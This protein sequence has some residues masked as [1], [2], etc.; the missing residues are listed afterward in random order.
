VTSFRKKETR[1]NQI[2]NTNILKLIVTFSFVSTLA[3]IAQSSSFTYQGRLNDGAVPA[4]G[5][6]DIQFALYDASSNGTQQGDL[7]TNSAVT[8]SNGLFTVLLDFGNQFPGAERWLQIGVRSNAVGSFTVVVPRQPLSASPYAI[9]AANL[10]G[11]VAASQ[12]TGT[13]PIGSLAGGYSNALTLANPGNNFSGNGA[14]LVGVNAASLQGLGTASLWQTTGNAGTTP[15]NNFI[16]TTDNQAFELRVNGFRGF[17]LQPN[18]GGSPNV[19]GGS[20]L[21]FISP[22]V[23]GATIAG[24]GSGTNFFKTLYTNSVTAD[25]GTVGGGVI[26]QVTN[27]CGTIGGGFGNTAGNLATVGG[28]E[29]NK[30]A[31]NIS[32]IIGGQQNLASGGLATVLG[33]YGNIASGDNSFAA[34]FEAQA[35]HFSSFVWAD[36]GDGATPY[37]STA[38]NQFSVRAAG[39]IRLAG[40]VQM[41]TD[42]ADYH[43]L[44]LNGGNSHGFLYGSYPYFGDGIH[45]GYN[46]YADANGSSHVINSGG[47]SSRVTAGYGEVVLAVGNIGLG[48]NSI[49]LDATLS[50]VTVSGTFNNNSDRNEKQDFAPVSPARILDEV[51]QLPLCEWSYKTDPKTR[52]VGPMAQDFQAAFRVGTDE[53]H[54][55]P[56]D[57]GGVALAAIQGLNQKLQ[58][59]LKR[60]DDENLELKKNNQA[61]AK[62]LAALEKI[63]LR[64]N[65]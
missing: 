48:P 47:G 50:G 18:P 65:P 43:H 31:G 32:T 60:R 44:E 40:D 5:T 25:Y 30:A 6:Y 54:I 21:N 51:T 22:N 36:F 52:H 49:R 46:F 33:G 62:R 37:S 35:L 57:E 64:S 12:L 23:Q 13:L 11:G 7:L 24:G 63:V 39:G 17:R 56:I 19:I 16:G 61:L 8:V 59:E 29:N 2:V 1:R 14:G 26:N 20:Q 45:L 3:V 42:T 41:D 55:A 58:A 15:T 10:T 34:G 27:F 4:N 38:N 9:T 28:G 53:K